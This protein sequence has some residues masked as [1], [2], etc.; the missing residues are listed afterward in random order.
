M[1]ENQRIQILRNAKT[2]FR[3]EIVNSHLE[4]ATKRAG[5]L[6][7]Y[8]LNPFLLAYLANFLEGKSSPESFATSL[9][10]R[11]LE[12]INIILETTRELF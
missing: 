11:S 4:G 1:N 2:F 6:K 3:N 7:S 12:S 9:S 10:I 8:N 5:S